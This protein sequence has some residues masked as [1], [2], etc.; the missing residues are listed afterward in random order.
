MKQT[1]YAIYLEAK[2]KRLQAILNNELKEGSKTD[3][4]LRAIILCYQFKA[5]VSSYPIVS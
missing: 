4:K 3:I 5:R 1:P 2:T